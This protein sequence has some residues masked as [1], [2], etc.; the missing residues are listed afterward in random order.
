M[1]ISK[2]ILNA[3]VRAYLSRFPVT[4]GKKHILRWMKNRTMPDEPV[5]TFRTKHGFELRV[6]LR[7]AEHQRMYFYG[8]HDER[9]EINNL[10]RIV[11][12]G[13]TCWDIGANIGFYTCLFASLVGR[14]G[15][16]VAFEPASAT[17]SYLR[18]N[19][20]INR[21]TADQVMVIKKAV[22]DA[23]LQKQLFFNVADM[24]EGTASL[25]SVQGGATELVQIDTLDNLYPALPLPDLIKID[26]EGYQWEV[27]A[28]GKN[29]FSHHHPMIMAEL[30]DND[31]DTVRRTQDYLCDLGYSFYEFKKHSLTRCTDIT[32]SKKRNFFMAKRECPHFS[33]LVISD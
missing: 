30:R 19:I 11:R 15:R 2:K 12:A 24:A 25:K 7:N 1:T 23:I 21:F 20:E 14:S 31:P 9:Y 22:G 26:V 10:K 27:L 16:I 28:G 6:N 29:F 13:D 33:R 17:A 5:A 4:E 3:I 18:K 32:R 8:E